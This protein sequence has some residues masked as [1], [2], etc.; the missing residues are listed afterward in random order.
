MSRKGERKEDGGRKTK[1]G[2]KHAR[3]EGTTK[4]IKEARSKG[5]Y[6]QEREGRLRR[7]TPWNGAR[8]LTESDWLS[9]LEGRKGR[10]GRDR[11]L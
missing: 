8:E 9:W 2:R 3:K 11:V 4:L 5:T 6:M 10:K 1:E 7:T